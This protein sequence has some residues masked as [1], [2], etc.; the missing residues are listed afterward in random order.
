MKFDNYATSKVAERRQTAN[1]IAAGRTP[2][3]R[4]DVQQRAERMRA[5]VQ[6]YRERHQAQ[7]HS[8]AVTR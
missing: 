8:Q 5:V 7:A 6:Q 1:V 2:E 3:Q 4:Q